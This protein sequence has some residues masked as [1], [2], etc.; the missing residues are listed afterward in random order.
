MTFLS[1]AAAHGLVIHDLIADGRWH[2]CRTDDKPRKRNGSYLFDGVRGVVINWATMTKASVWR[3]GGRAEQVD[4]AGIRRMQQQARV[5]DRR[6]RAAAR[7]LADQMVKQAVVGQHP[8]LIKKG[9]ADETGLV[10][11]GRFLICEGTPDEKEVVLEGDLLV[12]MR[13]FSLYRQINSVQHIA[14]DGTKLFLPYGKAQGSVFFIGSYMARERWL[15]E[16]LATGLS[17]RAALRQLYRE[18][19]IVV[20]FSAGNLAHVGALAKNLRPDAYVMADH[21]KPNPQTGKKAGE[22]AAIATGLPWVMP[23]EVGTDANDLHQSDG[24]AAL[25]RLIRGI[26]TGEE[27]AVG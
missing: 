1:H 26:R 19:Q 8:Y 14:S 15:V 27:M 10:L 3:E 25:V 23:P 20:C 16:G 7:D 21:D 22:E 12:P 18:A 6:R 5:D 9:F 11:S 24:V 17:V 13:E 2:R 4:R